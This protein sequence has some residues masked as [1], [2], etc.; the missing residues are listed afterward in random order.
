MKKEII[1]SVLVGL[2][3]GLIIVYGVYTAR[4]SL[5]QPTATQT[6]LTT[7]PS[8]EVTAP[9]QSQLVV[10]SPEDE[11]ITDQADLTVAGSSQ[12]QT[13]LVVFINEQAQILEPDQAGHFSAEV[14]LE[15]G[16]NI[17]QVHA[18]NEDGESLVEERTVIYTT[19]PL[20]EPTTESPLEATQSAESEG[21]AEGENDAES[22]LD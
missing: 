19:Q 15:L 9:A 2:I 22:E 10:H 8:P 16:S 12:A 3:F 21:G 17:I 6:T 4:S 20:V 7:T 1:I 11:I 14:E 18:L 13:Y 5:T